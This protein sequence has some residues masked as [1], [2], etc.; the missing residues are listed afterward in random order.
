MRFAFVVDSFEDVMIPRMLTYGD[1][2]V[3]LTWRVLMPFL[4]SSLWWD[5]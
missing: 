1:G 2:M 5:N 3:L 4:M